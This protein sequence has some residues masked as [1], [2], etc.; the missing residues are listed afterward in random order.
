M[1]HVTDTANAPCK[2]LEV[3]IVSR[4]DD[5]EFVECLKCGEV[6]DSEE[7]RDMLIEEQGEAPDADE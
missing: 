1:N 5:A 7:Y 2:H 3:R 6:F 4:H